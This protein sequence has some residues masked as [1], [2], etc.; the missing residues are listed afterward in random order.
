MCTVAMEADH[1]GMYLALKVVI[2]IG[3]GMVALALMRV[4]WWNIMYPI[5]EWPVSGP[6]CQLVAL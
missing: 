6:S 3:D 2:A 5:V 4:P 1:A